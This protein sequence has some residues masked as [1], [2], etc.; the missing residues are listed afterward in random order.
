MNDRGKRL[1]LGRDPNLTRISYNY[2]VVSRWHS[3]PV[4]CLAGQINA[5]HTYRPVCRDTL[6]LLRIVQSRYLRQLS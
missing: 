4:H 2:S 5:R 3:L 1:V 6:S